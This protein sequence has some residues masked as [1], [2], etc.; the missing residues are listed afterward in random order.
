MQ[1][2]YKYSSKDPVKKLEKTMVQMGFNKITI[3]AYIYYIAELINFSQK[4]PKIITAEDIIN[5]LESLV[6]KHKSRSTLNTAH[7]AFKFYFEKILNRKFFAPHGKIARAKP[8]KNF[9]VFLTE[10]EI[11][12]IITNTKSGKHKLIFNLMRETGI[13]ISETL[14]L[15]LKDL[16]FENKSIK[17]NKKQTNALRHNYVARKVSIPGELLRNIRQFTLDLKKTDFIFTNRKNIKLTERGI[18]K[19]FIAS[20]KKSNIY[21]PATCNSLRHSYAIRIVNQGQKVEDIQKLLGHKL[22]ETA[23]MYSNI[24]KDGKIKKKIKD[25]IN[26]KNENTKIRSKLNKDIGSGGI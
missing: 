26:I 23:L 16:D 25:L 1:H 13:K 21:K 10:K 19:T 4:S 18:Q 5:Y 15:Q 2:N 11:D 14:N 24:K 12:K 3:T 6:K 8:Q 9:P 7:S 17:I 20:L 22:S